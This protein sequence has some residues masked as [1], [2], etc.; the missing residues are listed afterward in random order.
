VQCPRRYRPER[1][2]E[3]DPI[4]VAAQ[5]SEPSGKNQIHV[6]I[7][8]TAQAKG[9]GTPVDDLETLTSWLRT[10]ANKSNGVTLLSGHKG[11][12]PDYQDTVMTEIAPG[13]TVPTAKEHFG[14][15]DGIGDP[16]LQDKLISSCV[17]ETPISTR[18]YLGTSIRGR[19][20]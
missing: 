12:N 5:Q 6:W 19:V 15:T 18:M 16:V 13:R 17:P 20:P 11:V 3:W 1:T 10:I 9:D 2:R 14:Y 4:W 8:L 7:S